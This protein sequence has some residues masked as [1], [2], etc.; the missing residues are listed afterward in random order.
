[1]GWAQNTVTEI[2][3]P[4]P[5]LERLGDGIGVIL[6]LETKVLLRQVLAH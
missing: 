1:M 2:Y 6:F 3:G 5:I 4:A